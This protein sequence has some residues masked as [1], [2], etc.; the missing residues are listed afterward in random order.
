MLAYPFTASLIREFL[1]FGTLI[2]LIVY[3]LGI[4]IRNISPEKYVPERRHPPEKSIRRERLL[5][6]RTF[7]AGNLNFLIEII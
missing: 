2:V 4:L 3:L 6:A 1:S 7:K 5:F